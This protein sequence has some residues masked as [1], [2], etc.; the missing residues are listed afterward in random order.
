MTHDKKEQIWFILVE[1]CGASEEPNPGFFVHFPKCREYRFCGSLGFGG[2]VWASRSPGFQPIYVT[3][4]PEDETPERAAAIH[5]A[6]KALALLEKKEEDDSHLH[7]ADI[8]AH[9]ENA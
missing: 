3:C 7:A 9:R 5:A 6:N 4:Y 8:E 2:K 1:E